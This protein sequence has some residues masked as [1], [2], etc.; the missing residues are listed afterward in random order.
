LDGGQRILIASSAGAVALAERVHLRGP[1]RD[2]YV[3][4]EHFYKA[5]WNV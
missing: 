2:I 3:P 4:G 5:R 1:H